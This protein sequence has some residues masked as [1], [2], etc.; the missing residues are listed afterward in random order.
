MSRCHATRW[1]GA[2][3]AWLAV[4]VCGIAA[5][6]VAQDTPLLRAAVRRRQDEGDVALGRGLF[7]LPVQGGR[8]RLYWR[9]F[10]E[11]DSVLRVG[12][13][14]ADGP[15]NRGVHGLASGSWGRRLL[16][17]SATSARRYI[18]AAADTD[19]GGTGGRRQLIGG[20]SRAVPPR[21]R[22]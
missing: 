8:R 11:L 21:R 5:L 18:I 7:L 14:D 15:P 20:W 3:R 2:S 6:V 12:P 16:W 9:E 13:S 4:G 1:E 19:N 17:R 22:A 10:G